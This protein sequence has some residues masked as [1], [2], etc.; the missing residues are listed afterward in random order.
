[1]RNGIARFFV[2]LTALW[3]PI[4]S[5]AAMDM[6]ACAHGKGAAAQ[7]HASDHEMH[8]AHH[9]DDDVG[10]PTGHADPQ[11]ADGECV[12]C[13]ACHLA[14][15]GF[16]PASRTVAAEIPADHIPVATAR[17]LAD[18]TSPD[19]LRRPPRPVA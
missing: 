14:C 3:L 12:S 4:Q 9:L 1:M 16:M 2:L 17:I 13:A 5:V 19:G 8:A 11:A 7:S 6:S 15:C 10:I 18:Q